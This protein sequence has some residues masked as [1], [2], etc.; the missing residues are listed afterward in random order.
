MRNRATLACLTI[1]A[2]VLTTPTILADWLVM[3]DGSRLETQGPW[4]EKG[5]LVV[6][7]NAQGALSSMRLSEI[8]L[9]ASRQATE[10]AK[11]PAEKPQE[12]ATE[13]APAERRKSVLVLRDGD[14]PR[15]D[16]DALRRAAAGLRNKKPVLFTTDW[17]GYCR[18]ARAV[19]ADMGLSY[20]ERDIEKDPV[21]KAE[22]T[23]RFG[24]A[25]VPILDLDG[26][27]L[28]GFNEAKMRRAVGQF[29]KKRAE[30]DTERVDSDS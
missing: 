2:A 5:R 19:L 29:Q 8:D 22:F 24:K 17:C 14:L 18:K 20:D 21:A 15:A 30:G 16:A 26:T 3:K 4:K 13:G 27:V 23:R 1:L 11:S 28:R 9:D 12:S 25:G 6:F 10:A 7:T